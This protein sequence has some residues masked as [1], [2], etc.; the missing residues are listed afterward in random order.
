[1]TTS[2]TDTQMVRFLFDPGCPWIW[3]ISQWIR[4][5]RRQEPLDVRWELYSLEYVNRANADNP[6]LPMLR[7]MRPALRLLEL[8]R[9]RAGNA[10]VDRLYLALGTAHHERG[11][12]LGDVAVL[13]RATEES[14]IE[15]AL[16]TAALKDTALD[17][18]LEQ[19]YAEIEQTGAIGVPT[20][21]IGD[22]APLTGRSS[23]PSLAVR[24]CEDCGTTCCT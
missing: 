16:L 22:A 18:E 10:A 13:R 12:D 5:V 20:L 19:Q 9:R 2:T 21:F 23:I 4:D 7:R 24:T 6:Y 3:R 1:M 15:Q 17:D 11:E 8:A 14:E